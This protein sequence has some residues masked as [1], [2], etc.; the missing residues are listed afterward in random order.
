M[1]WYLRV[2]ELDGGLWACRFGRLEYDTH[3]EM[4]Q[5]VDHITTLT[6]QYRPA[7]LMVHR[8]DGSVQKLGPVQRDR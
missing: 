4:G 7:E 5:A 3:A 8:L 1:A 6:A 2:V